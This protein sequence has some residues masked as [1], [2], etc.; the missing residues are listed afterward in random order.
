M[1]T[2]AK[3]LPLAITSLLLSGATPA[4]LPSISDESRLL[5]TLRRSI[6]D[7]QSAEHNRPTHGC[8]ETGQR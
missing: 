3:I 6:P 5:Q 1:Q 8:P 2:W 4:T 7:A